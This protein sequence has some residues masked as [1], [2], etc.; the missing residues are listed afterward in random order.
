MAVR[1]GSAI[2]SSIRWS[3]PA[4]VSCTSGSA[5]AFRSQDLTAC[6]VDQPGGGLAAR[7]AEP[8]LA[9][10]SD[11]RAVNLAPRMRD[12]RVRAGDQIEAKRLISA[13]VEVEQ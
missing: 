5:I 8:G 10:R 11:A 1:S 4:T 12:I 9:A 7:D 13:V 3:S 2:P 6:F